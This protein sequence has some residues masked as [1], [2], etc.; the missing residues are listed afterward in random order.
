MFVGE[1]VDEEWKSNSAE[2]FELIGSVLK[3]VTLLEKELDQKLEETS[4]DSIS[5]KEFIYNSPTPTTAEE[6]N[7]PST[8]KIDFTDID[9]VGS[10]DSVKEYKVR[11]RFLD[12]QEGKP[13]TS[14]HKI[15][16]DSQI[17]GVANNEVIDFNI[18]NWN[19]DD[20]SRQFEGRR[21]I[22]DNDLNQIP[23]SFINFIRLY[24]FA[25]LSQNTSIGNVSSCANYTRLIFDR[26]REFDE[27]VLMNQYNEVYKFLK[28][29]FI[30]QIIQITAISVVLPSSNRTR[31]IFYRGK[32]IEVIRR[33]SWYVECSSK[34]F[35]DTL[36]SCVFDNKRQILMDESCEKSV[37]ELI[38]ELGYGFELLFAHPNVFVF[39]K[40][41]DSHDARKLSGKML[42]QV[43][44]PWTDGVLL[45]TR[46]NKPE[47]THELFEQLLVRDFRLP[48]HMEEDW[49]EFME[50]EIISVNN[51]MLLVWELNF[52]QLNPWV[53]LPEIEFFIFFLP[54]QYEKKMHGSVV[55]SLSEDA[56][57]LPWRLSNRLPID[58]KLLHVGSTKT[59]TNASAKGDILKILVRSLRGNFEFLSLNTV[60]TVCHWLSTGQPR[61]I[62]HCLML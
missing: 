48:T 13:F 17:K 34:F 25:H 49:K 41:G 35:W 20:E 19:F 45:V 50:Q 59:S 29:C 46:E 32:K 21:C 53:C 28:I 15:V 52:L 14:G 54:K 30:I 6:G 36:A 58:I 51:T 1:S 47:N 18:L 3:E 26:G 9:G 12:Y 16:L 2:S 33:N 42:P 11:S 43:I 5:V 44:F 10:S 37:Y 60:A 55:Q 39:V 27:S 40:N 8:T 62:L 23:S 57:S 4:I 31:M 24:S 22:T 38:L 7:C 61:G 56:Y